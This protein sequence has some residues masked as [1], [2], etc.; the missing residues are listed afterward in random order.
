MSRPSAADPGRGQRREQRRAS[1]CSKITSFSTTDGTPIPISIGQGGSGGIAGGAAAANGTASTFNTSV[2]VRER[3]R[4]VQGQAAGGT[5]TC[6]DGGA[7]PATGSAAGSGSG[8]AGGPPWRGW[9]WWRW[10][11]AARISQASAAAA[12]TEVAGPERRAM[13][14]LAVR[15]STNSTA[16]GVGGTNS[17]KPGRSRFPKGPAAAVFSNPSFKLVNNYGNTGLAGQERFRSSRLLSAAAPTLLRPRSF[18]RA[19]RARRQ[20]PSPVM[21][22]AWRLS[23]RPAWC[24]PIISR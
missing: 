1:R 18:C 3:R 4:R 19:R 15:N 24:P 11:K 2:F 22:R 12:A 10:V 20:M 6:V 13:P 7:G 14:P 23:R 16:G 21:P 9:R 8:G 5:G 17:S